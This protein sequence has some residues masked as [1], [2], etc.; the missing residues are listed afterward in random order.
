MNRFYFASIVW[1]GII[2]GLTL[3]P[4]KS[5]PSVE[6]FTYDKLGHLVIF[7]V[8]SFLYVSGLYANKN[9]FKKSILIGL[10]ATVLYGAAIEVLQDFIPDR[11]MDWKD[12]AANCSGSTIGIIL[13]SITNK[14]N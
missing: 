2:L 11:S 3:T 12:L 6:L 13:F 9:G 8:L 10:I 1:S 5:L 14:K 4:G 7:L